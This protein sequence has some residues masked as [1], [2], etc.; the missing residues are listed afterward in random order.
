MG[1]VS[2]PGAAAAAAAP[3]PLGVGVGAGGSGGGRRVG[4]GGAHAQRLEDA[5]LGAE[6]VDELAVELEHGDAVGGQE[7]RVQHQGEG[8]RER[9]LARRVRLH[10]AGR[11][12]ARAE[13]LEGARAREVAH[14][15]VLG[16]GAVVE[17]EHVC[18]GVAED[19]ADGSCS[20][21]ELVSSV[22]RW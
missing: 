19:F 6:D 18:A 14:V 3:G 13:E 20:Y 9:G 10:V 16:E 12:G 4:A 11:D 1:V 2:V 8:P 22:C 5:A 17:E 21:A 15:G 7:G